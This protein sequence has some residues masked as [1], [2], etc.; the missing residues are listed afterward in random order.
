MVEE[1]ITA[2]RGLTGRARGSAEGS[3][4]INIGGTGGSMIEEVVGTSAV[5]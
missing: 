2:G 4:A 3:S 5:E 1:E